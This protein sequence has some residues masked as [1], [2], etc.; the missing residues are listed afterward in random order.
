MKKKKTRQD[1]LAIAEKVGR[2]KYESIYTISLRRKTHIYSIQVWSKKIKN[3][4][5]QLLG[6]D[7]PTIS[8][9]DSLLP[10]LNITICPSLTLTK[11]H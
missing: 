1:K 2:K 4:N 3:K 10:S 6:L 9:Y 5:G 8:A 7:K 11:K